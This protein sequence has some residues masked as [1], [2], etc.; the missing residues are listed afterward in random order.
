VI[1]GE[2]VSITGMPDMGPRIE[3]ILARSNQ[4]SLVA[5]LER[6]EDES[7][8][9]YVQGRMRYAG[10]LDR[11]RI[12]VLNGFDGPFDFRFGDVL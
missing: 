3:N 6:W 1:F 8:E 9:A 11:C 5:L 10:Y 2:T 4:R 12:A 7:N